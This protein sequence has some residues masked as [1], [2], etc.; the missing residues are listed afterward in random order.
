MEMTIERRMSR[1]KE[2]RG[3][4]EEKGSFIEKENVKTHSSE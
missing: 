2:R 4:R 1:I 3:K